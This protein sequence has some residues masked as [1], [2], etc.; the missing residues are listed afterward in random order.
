MRAKKVMSIVM[1][2]ILAC[3]L[4]GASSVAVFADEES[5]KA[6]SMTSDEASA[7]ISEI[8]EAD[9][10]DIKIG[11]TLMTY[12]MQFFQDMTAQA[13]ATAAELGVTLV[14]ND[15]KL[16]VTEQA[17]GVDDMIARGVD[18]LYLN[19][20]DGDAIGGSVL[21]ANAEGIPVIT[22]D[23]RAGDG[24]VEA[25]VS[26]DNIA[27]GKAAA[28]A[29]VQYIKE[30]NGSESGKVYV[31]G[32]DPASTLRDRAAGFI[33]YMEDYPEIETVFDQVTELSTE[34]SLSKMESALQTYGE[35]QLDVVFGANETNAVGV[36]SAATNAN[37][38]DFI[39]IGVDDS[40]VLNEMLEDPDSIYYASVVQ[41]PMTMGKLG[42]ELCV[43]A[44]NG[45]DMPADYV[46]TTLQ[47]ITKDTIGEY[48]EKLDAIRA[49]LKDYYD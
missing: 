20:V 45:I 9:N 2:G 49:D 26:S 17:N 29:A 48:L 1:T 47:T 33:E 35:G 25:H 44:A 37:R 5:A 6:E 8:Y 40:P 15:G 19:P 39:V 14:E 23:V 18:A 7:A 12:N 46:A 21:L 27:I 42:V 43:A 38:S 16:D 30:K 41:E 3:A 31:L 32:F 24:E 34:A 22:V 11:Y 10:S 36:V 13:R 4:F 28:E